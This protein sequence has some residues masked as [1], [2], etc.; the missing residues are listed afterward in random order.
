MSPSLFTGTLFSLSNP[1]HASKLNHFFPCAAALNDEGSVVCDG[2]SGID[3][4]KPVWLKIVVVELEAVELVVAELKVVE[5]EVVVMT[6]EMCSHG[7]VQPE[8]VLVYFV[9]VLEVVQLSLSV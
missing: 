3:H 2:R 5:L 1:R 9:V 4:T 6:C 7:G 8:P